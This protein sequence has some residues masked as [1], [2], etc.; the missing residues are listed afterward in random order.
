MIYIDVPRKTRLD[1]V[2][3]RDNYIGNTQQIIEKY[4]NRYFPAEDKYI[5]EC[6]PIM[7]ADYV[8]DNQDNTN[9]P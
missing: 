4:Q 8:I 5:E 2:L 6:N 7:N 1:R 9:T 3:E